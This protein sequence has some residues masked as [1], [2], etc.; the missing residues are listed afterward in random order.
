MA[1]VFAHPCL[2][3]APAGRLEER[4]TSVTD[5]SQAFALYLPPDYR[6]DRRWP[7]LF[8]LDPR[9]RALLGVKLF[10]EAAARLGWIIMSSYNTLS[11]GPAEPNFIAMNAMLASAQAD[12][13]VDR[14]R[15]YLAGFSGTARVA[16]RFAVLLHDH[17]AGVI[18]AGGAVGFELGG[19]EII[20]AHDSTFGYFGAAGTE[21]FNYEEVVALGDRFATTRVPSRVIVFDGPHSWPP[22]NLCGEALDWLE[23]RAMLGGR[24]AVDSAWVRTR[25]ADEL[26]R[27]SDL[28]QRGRW[29]EALRLDKAIARDYARWPDASGAAAAA[30]RLG[31]TPVVARY[32]SKALGLADRNLR[33]GEDVE[34]TIAWVRS[35][36]EPPARETLMRKPRIAELQK[37]VEVGDSLE[38]ASAKRLLARIFVRLAFYEPRTY[39][40]RDAPDRA[41][42]MFEAAVAIRP[43]PTGEICALFERARGVATAE[44]QVRLSGQCTP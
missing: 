12:L 40:E 39:L 37:R 41:V 11:D 14:S 15:L 35:Q 24:R 13:S 1:A 38:A 19:P 42:R 8:V 20:F 10:Q 31:N 17:V 9:G 6:G 33:E 25:L 5:T 27:A 32:E 21:D 3:Q 4:V 44:Q 28:E 43:L 34:K 16:L 29:E 36:H 23:L 2:G 18:G 30:A 7:I 22:A 26:A